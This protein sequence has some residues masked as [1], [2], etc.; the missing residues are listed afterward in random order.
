MAAEGKA[1]K[2]PGIRRPRSAGRADARR[3]AAVF[4][5]MKAG[6]WPREQNGPSEKSAGAYRRAA[7]AQGRG[8]D[9]GALRGAPSAGKPVR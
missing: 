8:Q 9:T 1:R 2:R 3:I 6:H 7:K 5:A 4:G